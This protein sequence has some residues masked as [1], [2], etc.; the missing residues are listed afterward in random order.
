L[1]V[2]AV[3]ALVALG[4]GLS[5]AALAAAELGSRDDDGFLMSPSQSLTTSTYAIA[6]SRLHLDV[7]TAG[8]VVP[9]SLLGDAKLTATPRNG[10]AVFLGIAPTSRARAYLAGVEHAALVDLA[11]SDPVYRTT[12]GSAPA[13]APAQMDFWAAQSSGPG[14]QQM[15]WPVEDGDW[16]VVVMNADASPDIAVEAAAGAE[17]P[18][19]SWLIGILL[20]VA[21]GALVLAVILIA[22]PLHA[23]GRGAQPS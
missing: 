17:V 2:G 8:P 22:V 19:L 1:V 20:T 4:A 3:L 9:E 6:S 18:A 12:G 15:T 5:G 21:G 11:D 14:P 7:D 13:A 10:K 16:T 23:A